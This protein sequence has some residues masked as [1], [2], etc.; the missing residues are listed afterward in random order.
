[1]GSSEKEIQNRTDAIK[2]FFLDWI[3]DNHNKIF[4]G[5]FLFAVI[6]RVYFFFKTLD[7]AVW[8]DAAD[9]LTQAKY[10]AGNLNFDYTFDPH[11]PFFL[12][13][14]WGILFRIGF[15]EITLRFTELL[16]SIAAIPAIYLVGKSLFN[17]KVGLISSFLLT[18]FWQHLFFSFRLMTEIPS[19]TF[20]IFAVYFFWEGYIKDRKKMLVWFAVF[21]SLS[22]LSRGGALVMFAVFPLFLLIKDKFK[23]LKNKQLWISA[24]I[25]FV[26]VST[27]FVF[28]YFKEGVNPLSRF[29]SLTPDSDLG[30]GGRFTNI[31][32]IDGIFQYAR[33]FPD[34]FGM[35]LL[36]I[37]IISL[38]IVL[39][40]VIINFDIILKKT[41]KNLISTLFVIIWAGVPFIY[42][43]VFV[44]HMEPRY[45]LMAFPGFFMIISIGFLKMKK[46]FQGKENLGIFFV[47]LILLLGAYFQLSQAN[48]SIISKSDSYKEVK[49]A[50]EW[51]KENTLESSVI[52]T[53]SRPQIYYYS[54]RKVYGILESKEEFETQ[55][56]E[57]K[58]N[59]LM[60][61]VFEGHPEWVY[62]YPSEHNNTFTPVKVYSQGEQPVLVIYEIKYT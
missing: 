26:F 14:L 54:E 60:I 37:F 58:P 41:P 50:G 53:R 20:F 8:W 44:G 59:Y 40:E 29:L 13:L 46:W 48:Q 35:I 57:I 30:G 31:M 18:I 10:L 33:F 6:I 24:M 17:K 1:M 52:F 28:I 5:I 21:L 34:Y 23:F 25:V 39:F 9:Y 16:F 56:E 19:L 47:I 61:S 42:N 12:A 49:Q 43:A 7:Q 62:S 11:R 32:G 27:F 38:L 15:G 36:V 3:K 4:L 51:L 55:L 2:N 22:F 45:I